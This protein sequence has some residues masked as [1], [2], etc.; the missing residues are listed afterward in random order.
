MM[1]A[2]IAGLLAA[3]EASGEVRRV[4][5]APL[6]VEESV[7]G[8]DAIKV[9]AGL[10]RILPEGEVEADLSAAGSGARR[11]VWRPG[12]ARDPV[13]TALELWGTAPEEYERRF[14]VTVESESEGGSEVADGEGRP[15]A[16]VRVRWRRGFRP[17]VG[18]EDPV[19]ECLVLR[20]V[21]REEALR[22]QVRCLRAWVDPATRRPRRVAV[23]EEG[24]RRVFVTGEWRAVPSSVGGAAEADSRKEAR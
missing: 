13:S 5:E 17:A 20:L 3:Q 2:A 9:A 21:P 15:R 14:S 16:P 1:F 24:L 12:M 22:S 8:S 10:L 18:P 4:L 6:R 7:A 23:E 19:A 11:I